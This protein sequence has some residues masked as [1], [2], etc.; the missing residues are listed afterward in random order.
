LRPVQSRVDDR[1]RLLHSCCQT[2]IA[3][4]QRRVGRFVSRLD[5]RRFGLSLVFSRLLG[6]VFDHLLLNALEQLR[7]P[8][9]RHRVKEK[10]R[11][12]EGRQRAAVPPEVETA[13]CLLHDVR[14]DRFCL[15]S[16]DCRI[17]SASKNRQANAARSDLRLL[18]FSG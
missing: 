11:G 4:R 9:R 6:C 2:A 10:C 5:D 8:D 7:I 1:A 12:D 17:T 13:S 18:K 16:L 14:P 15:H 3:F